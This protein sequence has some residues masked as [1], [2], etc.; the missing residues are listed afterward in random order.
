VLRNARF[1]STGEINN[2]NGKIAVAHKHHASK[3][4]RT[5][6]WGH[7]AHREET[8]IVKTPWPQFASELYR[9]SDR[10]LSAKLVPTFADRGCRV[11]SATYPHGSI[12]IFLDWDGCCNLKII[13][14]AA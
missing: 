13:R 6:E 10:R 8:G 14:F 7:L 9:P 12:L 1:V 11:V 4:L 2:Y 3:L 5:W